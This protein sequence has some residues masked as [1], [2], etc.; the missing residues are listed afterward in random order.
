MGITQQNELHY[1]AYDRIEL[2]TELL[3]LYTVKDM[4]TNRYHIYD[5]TELQTD[6]NI[7]FTIRQMEYLAMLEAGVTWLLNQYRRDLVAATN[8][9]IDLITATIAES[10]GA[11][12]HVDK[13]EN[14]ANFTAKKNIS[15]DLCLGDSGASCHMTDS[16]E[17]MYNCRDIKSPIKIGDGRTLY[18][19][20]IGTKKLVVIQK[21]GST[22]DITLE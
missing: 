1:F 11:F 7:S 12:I 22:L 13:E 15:N 19:T 17:G 20:K 16:N 3:D 14:N 6:K 10:D 21:D 18:A 9:E 8:S 5:V 2:V 4:M